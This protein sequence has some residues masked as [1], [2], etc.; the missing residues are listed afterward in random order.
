MI[1]NSDSGSSCDTMTPFELNPDDVG[2]LFNWFVYTLLQDYMVS[3]LKD[4]NLNIKWTS[5]KE[6]VSS[7]T[8]WF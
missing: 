3:Q 6:H 4:H 5:H 8:C 1:L 2:S 7:W